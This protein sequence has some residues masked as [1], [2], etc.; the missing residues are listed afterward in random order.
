MSKDSGKNIHKFSKFHSKFRYAQE[1]KSSW[2]LPKVELFKKYRT[3]PKVEKFVLSRR[4]KVADLSS[5]SSHS[6][7]FYV[8]FGCRSKKLRVD[9]IFVQM[10]FVKPPNYLFRK[11]KIEFTLNLK[12][13]EW[14]LDK[15]W[16]A[17]LFLR[18]I[19]KSIWYSTDEMFC[20]ND[21]HLRLILQALI[22]FI[23]SAGWTNR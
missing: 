1:P 12:W 16:S 4:F 9:K 5:H 17:R 22:C 3:L 8:Y 13:L 11:T 20:W 2:T 6:L 23:A 14:Y 21:L 15:F 19:F 18:S 10:G 7:I